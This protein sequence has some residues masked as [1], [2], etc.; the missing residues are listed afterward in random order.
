MYVVL[1]FRIFYSFLSGLAA[2]MCFLNHSTYF[3]TLT[4][5]RGK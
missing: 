5:A 2:E 1:E 3:R 4:K